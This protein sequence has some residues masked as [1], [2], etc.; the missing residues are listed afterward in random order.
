[1]KSNAASFSSRSTHPSADGDDRGVFFVDHDLRFTHIEGQEACH[2]F[3]PVDNTRF[4]GVSVW[5]V[6][7]GEA[8][9]AFH[10]VLKQLLEETGISKDAQVAVWRARVQPGGT[11]FCFETARDSSGF[12][13]RFHRYKTA[14][15][16]SSLA[17]REMSHN[18]ERASGVYDTLF[19]YCADPMA[20]IDE[21]GVVRQSNHAFTRAFGNHS[22]TV[23]FAE[24]VHPDEK[25]NALAF[26][27]S[28][29]TVE[30][31]SDGRLTCRCRLQSGEYRWYQWSF[32]GTADA[33][34]LW[35]A[36]GRDVTE[37]RA[38]EEEM[39]RR[40]YHDP[41]TDLPNRS[42][43]QDRLQSALA[44]APRRGATVAVLLFDLDRFKRIN[45]SLGHAAGDEALLEVAKRLRA[46][47][48][49]EDTV[50][51]L[52][53]DE[54]VVVLPAVR[55]VSDA[56]RVAEK[57]IARLSQPAMVGGRT[58]RF[59]ASVGIAVTPHDGS[60]VPQLLAAA[61]AAMY[62]YKRGVTETGAETTQA[63]LNGPLSGGKSRI[64]PAVPD[65]MEIEARL[66]FALERRELLL[67]YQPQICLSSNRVIGVEALMRWNPREIGTV[68]PGRFIPVAEESGLIC[69]LGEWAL[70]EACQ[71]AREWQLAGIGV[72]VAVN[73]S[74]SQLTDQR[75]PDRVGACLREAGVPAQ[76]IEI[77][78]TEGTFVRDDGAALETLSRLRTLGIGLFV[79]DFG[80]GYANLSYLR[81]FPI[82]GLKVDRSFV[83]NVDT[84]PADAAVVRSIVDLS[85]TLGLKVI[86]E[87]V[88]TAS[89][90]DTL[91]DLGCDIMQGYLFG[92]PAAPREMSA[93]LA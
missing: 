62:R 27:L 57:L 72:R 55:D 79:D 68:S 13:T 82:D 92:V 10:T 54:F 56:Y 53:G 51:R 58:V 38:Y 31:S 30:S 90:R 85:G 17:P 67:H 88:E 78:L 35:C 59:G 47:L 83:T 74:A 22:E 46:G 29:Q 23:L 32:S 3:A 71:Q 44:S 91:R 93:L 21:A 60:T 49:D 84:N 45:D 70:R 25:K 50:A 34:P 87:G 5:N 37:S 69:S 8:R 86:A 26:L 80:T 15:S 40:A 43:L 14:E 89:Q 66:G 76:Q 73:V 42:L 65:D 81:R 16:A 52:G 19:Q 39:R 11:V 41:L 24:L 77:E 63:V 9:T 33:P 6:F 75:F 7:R 2:L 4:N 61:D 12:V 18:G 20:A 64:P 1:M 36:S 28:R 48:R